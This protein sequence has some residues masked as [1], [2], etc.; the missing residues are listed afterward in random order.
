MPWKR[1]VIQQTGRQSL[2]LGVNARDIPNYYFQPCRAKA[3][4][5]AWI[6]GPKTSCVGSRERSG[7]VMM[8]K[9]A[10]QLFTSSP[11][12]SRQ[13]MTASAD[14]IGSEAQNNLGALL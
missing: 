7:W 12:R 13:A 5:G 2:G 14:E 8:K 3:E 4:V 1:R 9:A 11:E 10:R 6:T